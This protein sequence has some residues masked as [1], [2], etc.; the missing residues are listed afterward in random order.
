MDINTEENR[1]VLI[2]YF[3]HLGSD[4][5][6]ELLSEQTP[7]YIGGSFDGVHSHDIFSGSIYGDEYAYLRRPISKRGIGCKIPTGSV[8]INLGNLTL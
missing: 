3:P 1:K 4:H 6:Y 8:S 5:H 7:V 2:S